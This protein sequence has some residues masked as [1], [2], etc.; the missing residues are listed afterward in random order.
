MHPFASRER[1]TD[2]AVT[3]SHEAYEEFVCFG[4]PDEYPKSTQDVV[5]EL[6][7]RGYDAS[8]PVLNY[9]IRQEK[10]T[11]SREGRNYEWEPE[12]VEQVARYLEDQEAYTPAAV[13]NAVLGID[14]EQ[15]H[16]ALRDAMDEVREEFGEV[17]VP[18]NSVPDWF[19]MHVHP[20]RLKGDGYVSFTLCDDVRERLED[21]RLTA[22]G[23]K[24]AVKSSKKRGKKR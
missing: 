8:V 15:Y 10:V 18:V 3:L 6:R 1:T 11:P 7:C 9:L 17:I 14:F 13:C 20:P 5:S 19:V 22:R 16:R 2:M 12:H 4:R 21:Q 23:I 24:L